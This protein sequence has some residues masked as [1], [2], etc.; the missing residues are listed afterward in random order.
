MAPQ[1]RRSFRGK[2]KKMSRENV[3]DCERIMRNEFLPGVNPS[4]FVADFNAV[5]A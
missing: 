3:P 2:W 4:S 5:S 1:V